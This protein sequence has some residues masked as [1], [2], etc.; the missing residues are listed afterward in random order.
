MSRSYLILRLNRQFERAHSGFAGL[1]SERRLEPAIASRPIRVKIH[2]RKV[3]ARAYILLRRTVLVGLRVVPVLRPI[4]RKCL[5]SLGSKAVSKEAQLDR[6]WS[7]ER[8]DSKSR[9]VPSDG[10]SFSVA[11]C[12]TLQAELFQMLTPQHEAASQDVSFSRDHSD[13]LEAMNQPP[14]SK[15]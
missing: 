1:V 13:L 6:C 8:P 5:S 4:W 9:R 3:L 11:L 15:N 7:R 2:Q 10:G 14:D 12:P